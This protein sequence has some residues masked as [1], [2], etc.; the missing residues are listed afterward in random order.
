MRICPRGHRTHL[1]PLYISSKLNNHPHWLILNNTCKAKFHLQNC[2]LGSFTFYMEYGYI[3]I[4]NSE[5]SLQ[6]LSVESLIS[7]VG[8][9]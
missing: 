1:C 4:D 5:E 7:D 3:S 2:A 9:I 6:F 8:S